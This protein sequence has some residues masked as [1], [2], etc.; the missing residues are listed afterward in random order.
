MA[1]L[2]VTEA[3]DPCM[4]SDAII[5]HRSATLNDEGVFVKNDDEQENFS[6]V[7]LP[8][9]TTKPTGEVE[10]E[11][12]VKSLSIFI[13]KKL[14]KIQ[15]NIAPADIILWENVRYKVNE[16]KDYSFYGAGYLHVIAELED[17]SNGGK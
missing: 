17:A 8:N 11:Y 9:N 2:D 15:T 14:A 6:A 7:I 13:P 10:N 5:I 12:I 4:M 1:S 3:F 16:I